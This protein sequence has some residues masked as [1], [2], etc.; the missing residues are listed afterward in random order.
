M[1][2]LHHGKAQ[3][4]IYL[5]ILRTIYEMDRNSYLIEIAT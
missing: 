1:N 2:D 5:D 3:P 4:N